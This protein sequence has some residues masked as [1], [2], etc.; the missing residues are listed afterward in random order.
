MFVILL[1]LNGMTDF[2]VFFVLLGCLDGSQLDQIGGAVFDIQK[3]RG[4]SRGWVASCFSNSYFL[5]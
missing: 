4:R 3:T 2:D 1:L 5:F